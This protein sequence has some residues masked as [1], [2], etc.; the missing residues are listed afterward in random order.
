MT[1][2][3]TRSKSKQRTK[4]KNHKGSDKIDIRLSKTEII[5]IEQARAINCVQQVSES[6]DGKAPRKIFTSLAFVVIVIAS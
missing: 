4:G 3:E 1:I 6:E 2:P 5:R